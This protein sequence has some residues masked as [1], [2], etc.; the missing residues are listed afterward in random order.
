[1]ELKYLCCCA[2]GLM[3]SLVAVDAAAA[4]RM[5]DRPI[6]IRP[7]GSSS[8]IVIVTVIGCHYESSW[9]P[10]QYWPV[11]TSTNVPVDYS[12]TLCVLDTRYGS[13]SWGD[14]SAAQK[15]DLDAQYV[16]GYPFLAGR[17]G[18]ASAQYNCFGLTAGY[19]NANIGNM[20]FGEFCLCGDFYQSYESG[21]DSAAHDAS[22]P[23]IGLADHASAS[24]TTE[25]LILPP[26]WPPVPIYW[27]TG[28]YD[29]FGTYTIRLY[30]LHTICPGSDVFMHRR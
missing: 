20:A 17:G 30:N 4:W 16:S 12:T 10:P 1:M 24:K 13:L 19:H 2:L 8:Y 23:L 27:Y 26:P 29:Y 25:R 14:F 11:R 18:G 28:K 15:T 21:A 6:E 9:G 22:W 3:S 5:E 7:P